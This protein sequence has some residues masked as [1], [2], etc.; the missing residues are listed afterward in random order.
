MSS[1]TMD[2]NMAVQVH[3]VS[4]VYDKARVG[5]CRIIAARTVHQA[6][7]QALDLIPFS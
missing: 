4:K 3:G 7:F 2:S 1:D 5:G 6:R